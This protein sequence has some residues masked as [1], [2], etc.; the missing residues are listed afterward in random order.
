MKK[1]V[2]GVL[3]IGFITVQACT[4][5]EGERTGVIT[6]FS[7]KGVIF[8]TWEGTMTLGAE[9]ASG[10]LENIWKFSVEKMGGGNLDLIKQV[11]DVARSGK[12]ATLGYREI[13]PQIPWRGESRYFITHIIQKK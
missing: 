10:T 13:I 3:L 7:R 4:Y 5:S 12:L 2:Y 9:G 11:E 8:K 6:K 1:L